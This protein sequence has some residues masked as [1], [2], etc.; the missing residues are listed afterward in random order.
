MKSFKFTFLVT[1]ALAVAAGVAQ[2]QTIPTIPLTVSAAVYY[3]PEGSTKIKAVSINNQVLLQK[4]ANALGKDNDGVA[5]IKSSYKLAVANNGDIVIIDSAGEI[6]YNLTDGV[7]I[8]GDNE[9]WTTGPNGAD[10]RSYKNRWVYI[11]SEYNVYFWDPVWSGTI[12]N[13]DETINLKG[14]AISDWLRLYIGSE[15]KVWNSDTGRTITTQYV[16]ESFELG[17][18]SAATLAVAY[19]DGAYTKNSFV[20]TLGGWCWLESW[21]YN[22]LTDVT[23]TAVDDYGIIVGTMSASGKFP[24][25]YN[26]F[27]NPMG[28]GN[29]DWGW[30]GWY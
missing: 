19:A 18:S 22:P 7:S 1:A 16:D 29:F 27:L 17:D 9:K 30:L 21:V 6:V 2:A 15:S 20:I 26:S 25:E 24:A 28:G 3:K 23:T 13:N 12:N 4:I 11:G 5:R 8:N 10:V 14:N